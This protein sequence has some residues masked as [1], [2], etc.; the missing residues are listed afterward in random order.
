MLYGIVFLDMPSRFIIKE[1]GADSFYHVF[2]RGVNKLPIFLDE[3]DLNRFIKIMQRYLDPEDS[4]KSPGG[5]SYRK[6]G[7]DLQLLCF[8]LMRNHIHLLI[9]QTSENVCLPNFMRSVSTAYVKY[10]NKKYKR[11][12]PLFQSVYKAS[13][14]SDDSYLLHI[15]RYIHMNPSNYDSYKWSSLN[16]Y[17][18]KEESGWLKPQPI[19]ELFEGDDYL[20]FLRDYETEKEELELVKSELADSIV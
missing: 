5:E 20:Q 15:S 6:Y 17:V 1:F 8:C 12:G 2:N 16:A 9:K 18:N 11:V 4:S 10:F 7:D 19:L 13:R 14:I 3:F